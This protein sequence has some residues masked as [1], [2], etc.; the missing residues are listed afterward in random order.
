MPN[1]LKLT[2]FFCAELVLNFFVKNSYLSRLTIF[3]KIEVFPSKQVQIL[4]YFQEV[5]LEKLTELDF[6]FFAKFE[7][8]LKIKS[9][10]NY[11]KIN[12]IQFLFFCQNLKILPMVL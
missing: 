6:E 5:N 12:F 3:A 8:L 11:Q 2:T 1:V 10:K 7:N 4:K 9:S